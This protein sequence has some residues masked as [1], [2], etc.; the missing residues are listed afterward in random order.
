MRLVF[1]WPQTEWGGDGGEKSASGD[2]RKRSRT[3]SGSFMARVIWERGPSSVSGA[4]HWGQA[5]S[6]SGWRGFTRAHF[7]LV[8][9]SSCLAFSS[10]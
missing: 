9:E 5:S 8:A 10:R 2:N 6:A 3:G 4:R 1:L 7:S